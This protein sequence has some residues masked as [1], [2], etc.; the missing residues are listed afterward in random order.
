MATSR[1]EHILTF[2]FGDSP[3][4]SDIYRQRRKLW[5][6]KQPNIDQEIREHFL[7]DYQ[8][9][10][11]GFYSDWQQSPDGCLALILLLDQFPRNMFRNSP[12]SY[13]T[14]AFARSVTRNA[15]A[16]GFDCLLSPVQQAFLYLPLEHS[17][18]F[19]DQN[20]NVKLM[21]VVVAAAPELGNMYDYALRHRDVIQ[22]FGRFPHRN[23][24]LERLNTPDETAFLQQPGSLF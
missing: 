21:A 18:C 1:I 2:W 24:I 20:Q 11:Q 10:R 22:R 16:Q 12:R 7:A 23:A 13:A 15:I 9:A 19:E 4:D 6:G 3:V 5:F 17:E 8:Q 14:D